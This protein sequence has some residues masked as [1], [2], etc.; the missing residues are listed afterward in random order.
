MEILP[1]PALD[2]AFKGQLIERRGSLADVKH[3]CHTMHGIVSTYQ[4]LGCAKVFP[5]QCF[6]MIPKIGATI[7]ATMQGEIR[8]HEIAHCN[9]WAGNHPH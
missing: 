8:R 7:S 6:I 1:P 3:Y 2:H 4:A 9:G 5:R